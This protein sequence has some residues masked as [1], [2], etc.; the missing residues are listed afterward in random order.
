MKYLSSIYFI[1]IIVFLCGSA[2][3]QYAIPQ[4]VFGNGGNTIS[5]GNNQIISTVG[6]T[7]IGA[8]SSTA[9][10]HGIGFWQV[11]PYCYPNDSTEVEEIADEVLPLIYQLKQNYPNPF[12]PRTVI[13]Y[14]V[15]E[16]THVTIKVYNVL[17]EEIKTLVDRT[18]SPGIYQIVWS[19]DN[20]A[21]GIYFIRLNAGEFNQ[22]RKAV[23]LK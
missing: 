19:P 12:N 15:P 5:S 21:S 11:L 13:E 22:T 14:S 6:Q 1:T 4:S 7:F 17:G 16:M 9:Y 18:E 23:F 8:A 2:F 20:I 3:G 10:C